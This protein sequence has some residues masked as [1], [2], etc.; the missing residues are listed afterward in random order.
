MTYSLE[1]AGLRLRSIK[2]LL[3]QAAHTVL[4]TPA[5]ADH[6]HYAY[7]PTV[8]GIDPDVARYCRATAAA[9]GQSGLVAKLIIYC[10]QS[11]KATHRTW[12][13]AMHCSAKCCI[14][15]LSENS[16]HAALHSIHA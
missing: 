8:S 10:K 13:I 9:A 2:W 4:S 15:L 14:T 6:D 1:P 11:A 7:L 12:C 5:G 16:G 3:Y